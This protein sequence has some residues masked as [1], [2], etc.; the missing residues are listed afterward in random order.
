M[1]TWW[2]II[3][4]IPIGDATLQ[5]AF[6]PIKEPENAKTEEVIPINK[7]RV[8]KGLLAAIMLPGGRIKIVYTRVPRYRVPG[9]MY[10]VPA[11]QGHTISKIDHKTKKPARYNSFRLSTSLS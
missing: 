3:P 2:Q 8:A 11:P 4:C 1:W 5:R 9:Y 7:R 6:S 10:P